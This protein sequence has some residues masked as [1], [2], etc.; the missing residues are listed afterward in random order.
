M[1]KIL[2]LLLSV[3]TLSLHSQTKLQSSIQEYYDGTSWITIFGSDYEYDNNKNLI[4]EYG[5]FPIGTSWTKSN[6]TTYTYNAN[7]KVT[8]E[9]EST[10]D[11]TNQYI[12]L[13]KTDYTYNTQ[14]LLTQILEMD[15]NGSQWENAYKQ[16]IGYNNNQLFSVEA[17]YFD[18]SQWVVDG[19]MGFTYTGN[20]LTQILFEYFDGNSWFLNDR[21]TLVYNS[22][23]QIKTTI[24]EEFD[25]S[26][27]V[28]NEIKQTDFDASFNRIKETIFYQGITESKVEYDYDLTEQMSSFTHPFNDKIGVD[29][30]MESF[31]YVNKILSTTEYAYDTQVD[32]FYLYGKTTYNYNNSLVLGIESNDEI[33]I[34]NLYPNPSNN[35]IQLSGISKPEKVV[36]YSLSGVK[37]IETIINEN[38]KIDIQNLSNGLYLMKLEN[39]NTLKFSKN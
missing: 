11:G 2:L 13:Y 18:G 36:V 21:I 16:E 31:P 25:G 30:I 35:F 5:Y 15:W 6:K 28:E 33:K 12:N 10:W 20:N 29:Y 23:N 38:E 26:T 39:G 4:T 19:R 27:W 34:I 24:E 32:D 1:K 14:G 17:N 8:Q 7:N 22:N 37:M 9:V 3:V